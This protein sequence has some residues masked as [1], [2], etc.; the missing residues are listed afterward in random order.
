M[1]SQ[2]VEGPGEQDRD[3]SEDEL[4]RLWSDEVDR[5]DESDG[6]E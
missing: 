6:V 4:Y 5:R 3:R 1:I 2:G